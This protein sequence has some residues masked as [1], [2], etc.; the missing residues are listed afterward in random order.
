[1]RFRDEL[2]AVLATLA[3]VALRV[4]FLTRPMRTDEAATFLYYASQPLKVG[5]SVY[6]S[7]NNH[8]LHTALMH[9]A[10]RAFG[11]AEWALRLPALVAGIA[12]VPLAFVAARALGLGR[13]L[14]AASLAATWPLLVDY[15]TDGRG[16]TLVCA[17]TLASL[18]AMHALRRDGN[19]TA[20]L[21]FVLC[22]TL[23]FWSVPVMIYPFALLAVWGLASK[24]WPRVL[25]AL[26]GTVVLTFVVYL[27]VLVT[28]GLE[29]LTQNPWVRPLPWGAFFAA[30]PHALAG[31]WQSWTSGIP[32]V[33]AL[34]LAALFI[35]GAIRGRVALWL[36]LP[37]VAAVLLA[38]HTIP[39]PRTWLPLLAIAIVT[40][41]A[42]LPPRFDLFGACILAILLAT[43]TLTIHRRAETGELPYVR[44][45]AHYLK[46]N[47]KPTDAVG[48][49][50]PSDVPL[51]FY[52][53]DPRPLS[54]NVNA[55]RIWI[56]TNEDFGQVLPKTLFELRID[57]R[58]FN[59]AKRV[60]FGE[61][62]VYQL[63]RR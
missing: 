19:R 10:F 16:Y 38:Q 17:F 20:G 29:A 26:C 25:A 15:S 33:L 27:P 50:S 6:G 32:L 46:D 7:P 60:D 18:I 41:N 8:L 48:T 61:V 2:F 12:L 9:A 3:A 49:L 13:G 44:E 21:L 5:L 53:R 14:L 40:M 37:A 45:I 4:P 39:F 58:G 24:Q 52:L 47:A 23:G 22:A 34:V 31:V 30:L 35:A 57:P 1:M 62:A 55:S 56:V 11:S 28:S 59:I 54:P 43:C 36:A 51:A 63:D 42:A